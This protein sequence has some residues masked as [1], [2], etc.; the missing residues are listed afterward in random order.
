MFL[1]VF[2]K[3]IKVKKTL[4]LLNENIINNKICHFNIFLK[5]FEHLKRTGQFTTNMEDNISSQIEN[6]KHKKIK[7]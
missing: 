1:L 7:T 5:C 3:Q 6:L 2:L 4:L